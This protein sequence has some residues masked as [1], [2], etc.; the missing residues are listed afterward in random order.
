M[1]CVIHQ[2]GKYVWVKLTQ[3][4]DYY[5]IEIIDQGPGIP[6]QYLDRIF[7]PFFRVDNSRMAENDSFGLGLALAKRHLNSIRGTVT[8]KNETLEGLSVVIMIPIS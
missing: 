6:E 2:K 8:A 7:N 5:C 1:R 3:A 4:N